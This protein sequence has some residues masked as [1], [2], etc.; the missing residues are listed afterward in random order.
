[1]K[2]NIWRTAALLLLLAVSVGFGFAFDA[3]ATAIERSHHPQPEQWRTLIEENAELYGIPEVSLWAIVSEGSGFS[4]NAVSADGRI[5]LMQLSP[6]KFAQ[7]S[8][9]LFG[10][11]D[12]DPRLLYDPAT[13][14]TAD[15]VSTFANRYGIEG[16]M[17]GVSSAAEMLNNVVGM[18]LVIGANTIARKASDVSLY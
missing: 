14:I 10:K 1:M 18:L 3:V 17:I 4:S 11:S 12:P 15:V 2:W 13:Y 16:A 5:G 8:L 7:I 9:E 6:E